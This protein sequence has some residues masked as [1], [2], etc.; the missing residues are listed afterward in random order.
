M[1]LER[2]IDTSKLNNGNIVEAVIEYEDV[3]GKIVGEEELFRIRK[4]SGGMDVLGRTL[5]LTNNRREIAV[6]VIDVLDGLHTSE[7]GRIRF[8]R[9]LTPKELKRELAAGN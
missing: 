3:T 1:D 8:I 9:A 2:S 5:V 4:R 7:Q 6:P